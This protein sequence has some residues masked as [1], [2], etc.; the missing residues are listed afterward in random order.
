MR[1]R[2]VW[3]MTCLIASLMIPV[4]NVVAGSRSDV[5]NDVNL[6]LAGKCLLYSFSY[7]RMVSE[8]F[9]IELGLSLLGG[10]SS[11][12][13]SSIFFFT[14]GGRLYFIPKNASPFIT[15]G[16]VLLSASSSSG[17]FSNSSS[18][19]YGYVGPGFEYRSEGGFLVRGSVYAL[20]A[21]G[22]FFVW[23]GLTIGIAF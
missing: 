22:G 18:S 6:E 10:G 1:T 13:T 5:P 21:S 14:V 11:N 3:L 23:P 8:P 17:P 12:T 16:I 4:D 15:G 9:G 19:S 7:Q 20:L 2:N